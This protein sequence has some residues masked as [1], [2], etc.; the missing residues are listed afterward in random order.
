MYKFFMD[1]VRVQH[2]SYIGRSLVSHFGRFTGVLVRVRGGCSYIR[3]R[4][5]VLEQ[6]FDF[7]TD[8]A[9]PRTFLERSEIT[10]L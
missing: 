4:E 9:V 2:P 10:L 7:D 5:N 3:L 6:P 8:W 1:I